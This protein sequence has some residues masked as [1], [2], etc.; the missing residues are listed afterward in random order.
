MAT[1][2]AK[3]G[4][5]HAHGCPRCHYRHEDAC[6]DPY[7]DRL[8][9]KC[10]GG[11]AWELIRKNTEP[12][13]CCRQFSRLASK[14][15]VESYRLAGSCLWFFCPKCARTHPYVNPRK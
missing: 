3:G 1:R 2:R 10:R 8:C 13:D 5:R 12:D 15:E 6:R 14:D 11:K 4:E 7:D 9:I